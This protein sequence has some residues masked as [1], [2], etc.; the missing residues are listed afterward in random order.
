[1]NNLAGKEGS[2][3]AAIELSDDSRDKLRAAV[4]HDRPD[5]GDGLGADYRQAVAE[6]FAGLSERDRGCVGRAEETFY[7]GH[8]SVAQEIASGLPP[9]PKHW[10]AVDVA[11][12][13][14]RDRAAA[15]AEA[16]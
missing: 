1:M 16:R 5:P 7:A 3:M 13:L 4:N 11:P 10:M 8:E 15:G 6:W 12:D 14:E 2:A 9:A